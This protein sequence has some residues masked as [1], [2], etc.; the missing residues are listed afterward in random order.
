[1]R[2]TAHARSSAAPA[3][4][5][6]T[7][8]PAATPPG[9]PAAAPAA[10]HLHA[11]ERQRVVLQAADA[12]WLPTPLAGV[13]RRWLDHQ[14]GTPVHATSLVRYARGAQAGRHVHDGGEEVL[15]LEGVLSD[16]TGDHPAG[17][18]LRLPP[19]SAHAPFSRQGCLLYVKRSR[20]A[21][22]DQARL[23]ID[24]RDPALWQQ[25][26]VPGIALLPLHSHGVLRTMLL[27]SAPN[28]W[29]DTH[30]HPGGEELLVL[31]GVLSDDL[32]RYPRHTWVRS[33]RWSRHAPYTGAEGALSLIKLGHLGG[34]GGTGGPGGPGGPAGATGPGAGPGMGRGAVRGTQADG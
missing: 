13:Q 1:M 11:D 15:V 5:S 3:E 23:R 6:A 14:G 19:G 32:G 22:D 20:F 17:T 18:Y 33:P 10:S 27:R 12:V 21:P 26:G 8:R 9:A 31:D 28:T 16:E 34:A 7:P 29:F 2:S 4:V 24:T 30:S 25:G